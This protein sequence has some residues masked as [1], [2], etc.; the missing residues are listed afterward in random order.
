MQFI[1]SIALTCR[2]QQASSGGWLW[3]TTMAEGQKTFSISLALHID[4]T[5]TSA[6]KLINKH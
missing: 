2:L 3:L 1:M 6:D 5:K 4:N